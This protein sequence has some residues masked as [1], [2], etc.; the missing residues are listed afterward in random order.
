M[1]SQ[2]HVHILENQDPLFLGLLHRQLN[3]CIQLTTGKIHQDLPHYQMLVAGRPDPAALSH[4]P[5]L[6]WLVIPFAG[7]P[8]ETQGLMQN[9]PTISVHNLHHNARPTAELALALLFAAA[10]NLLPYDQALRKSDWTP[11]YEGNPGL[12]LHGCPVCIFGF[13]AVGKEVGRLCS[14]LDMEV[15]GVRAGAQPGEIW[16]GIPV[17]PTALLQKQLVKTQILILT[18]P[19][20]E[21]TRGLIAKEEL[22]ML[23]KP[24]VLIN[25][26]RGQVVEEEALYE[27]LFDGTL[28][29]AG[30][31]VWY[32]YPSD[33][34]SRRSTQPSRYPF[35]KL[36]NVVLSPH[37]GGASD[38]TEVLR[39]EALAHLIH[40]ASKGEELWNRVDLDRGY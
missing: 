31:D 40:A 10:K 2:L 9:Y 29:A 22:C 34:P 5:A 7:V 36:P 25:I 11:R 24:S 38:Q 12:L 13:G 19:L 30:L 33:R 3:N 32:A 23:R 35:F 4:S 21:N 18:V 16:K 6:Q 20:T 8:V 15:T 37:R 27:A 39:A 1:I 17:L 28:S 26:S 14:A